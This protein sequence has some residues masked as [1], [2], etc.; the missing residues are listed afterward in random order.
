MR[1]IHFCRQKS[2]WWQWFLFLRTVDASFQFYG[3]L[4]HV[5]FSYNQMTELPDKCFA[6]QSKLKHL[7]MDFNSIGNITNQTFLGLKSLTYLSLRGNKLSNLNEELA[8]LTEV[9]HT[10]ILYFTYFNVSTLLKATMVKQK[11]FDE[12]V[13]H[14]QSWLIHMYLLPTFESDPKLICCSCRY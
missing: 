3:Q 7:Q 13:P 4:E 8:A 1:S 14:K 10:Y 11:E 12:L 6:K 2:F 9:I 5:D